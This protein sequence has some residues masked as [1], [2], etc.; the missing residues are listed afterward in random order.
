[1]S[2]LDPSSWSVE[3]V[4]GDVRTILVANPSRAAM[5]MW[6]QGMTSTTYLRIALTILLDEERIV[7]ALQATKTLESDDKQDDTD[8]RPCELAL[9]SDAPGGRDEASVD[10]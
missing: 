8:A 2:E 9:G 6:I 3:R 7:L 5:I 4:Y 1:M 10:G